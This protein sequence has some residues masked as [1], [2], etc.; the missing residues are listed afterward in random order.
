MRHS[1][2]HG[3]LV[4]LCIGLIHA[5]VPQVMAQE[6]PA[7]ERYGGTTQDYAAQFADV[8]VE[9][10]TFWSA[11]FTEA[12]VPYRAPSVV[13]L[14]APTTTACG[15]AGPESFASYCPLDETI[16]YSPAAFATHRL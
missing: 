6:T 13:A 4:L 10:N 9:L 8:I 3:V 7:P 12:G 1:P 15:P 11:I 14:D 16:Y 2:L 5:S